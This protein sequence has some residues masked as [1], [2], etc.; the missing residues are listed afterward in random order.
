[1]PEFFNDMDFLNLI[2][3]LLNP[4][5]EF[6]V[7]VNSGGSISF[8]PEHNFLS[9]KN[10]VNLFEFLKLDEDHE[11][12]RKLKD[13]FAAGTAFDF[14][15]AMVINDHRVFIHI[16]S[17]SCPEKD[18]HILFI[19]SKT[20]YINTL[21]SSN[22]RYNLLKAVLTTSVN[23]IIIID[24]SGIMI[25]V[26]PATSELFGYSKEELIGQ[27][28]NMLMT[29]QYAREHDSYMNKYKDTGRSEVTGTKRD[30]VAR[31]K[32][33][34]EFPIELSLSGMSHC[35]DAKFTGIISD[36]TEKKN[37]EK[38]ILDESEKLMKQYGILLQLNQ[39]ISLRNEEI[40]SQQEEI[41]TQRNFALEQ[42]KEIELQKGEIMDSI[43]YAQRIQ[44][45]SLPMQ[46][47]LDFIFPKHFILFEPKDI[48]SGDFYWAFK[49]NEYTLFA[50]GDCTGHGVPGSFLTI[51]GIAFLNEIAA[52]TSVP[53]PAIIL[54]KLRMKIIKSL[55]QTDTNSIIS[56]GMDIALC[57]IN[58]NTKEL[59]FA[60]ANSPAYVLR[61]GH[62]EDN[63]L[64]SNNFIELKGDKMPIGAFMLENRPYLKQTL[65]LREKDMIYIFSDG[66]KD[67]IGGPNSKKYKASQFKNF[68]AQIFCMPVNEQCEMLK[69]NLRYW[70]TNK[71][72]DNFN[73]MQTDDICIMGVRFTYEHV[74]PDKISN[75][76]YDWDL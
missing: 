24:G 52:L 61:A 6:I 8:I 9:L 71:S 49:I 32:S 23:A 17:V 16:S 70:R 28:V 36:I 72:D 12:F 29:D 69:S 47:F 34:V 30:L 1:M 68:L 58:E 73:H 76:N 38:K 50:V 18:C 65:Q 54:D 2:S 43:I 39:D 37:Y 25:E 75:R 41:V 74:P 31:K 3:G 60:G 22:E 35:G 5:E 19:K 4:D 14:A 53:D 10:H 48:V 46:V 66:I 11:N 15:C 51:L 59:Y 40:K 7:T 62:E 20:Q 42:K 26:N 57:V 63:G 44:N 64:Y 21:K 13:S 67:Q 33:G 45:A 56:D 55:H 27:N